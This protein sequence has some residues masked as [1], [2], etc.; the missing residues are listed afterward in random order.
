MKTGV[1][2][3]T[4]SP[5]VIANKRASLR[6]NYAPVGASGMVES[7]VE[8]L[9]SSAVDDE[10]DIGVKSNLGQRL[11]LLRSNLESASDVGGDASQ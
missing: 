8:D 9:E 7:A 5:L 1:V 3:T 6:G 11:D 4:H 2:S 10:L